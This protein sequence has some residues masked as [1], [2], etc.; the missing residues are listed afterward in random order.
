MVVKDRRGRRRYIAFEVV[1]DEPVDPMEFKK[2]IAG[3]ASRLGVDP[4]KLIQYEK[5]RGII[6]CPHTEAKIMI[7]TLQGIVEIDRKE[8]RVR[9]LRTSGTIRTLRERYFKVDM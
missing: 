9:T 7:K 6:R 3:E 2:A 1:C 8:A 5:G 4:P